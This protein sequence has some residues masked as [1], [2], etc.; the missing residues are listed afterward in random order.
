M[1]TDQ[2]SAKEIADRQA[3]AEAGVYVFFFALKA[4]VFVGSY[5]LIVY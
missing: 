4:I 1:G 3:E 5:I 2:R